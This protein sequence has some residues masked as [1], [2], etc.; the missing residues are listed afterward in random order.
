MDVKLPQTPNRFIQWFR[1]KRRPAT[2]PL[3]ERKEK[4]PPPQENAR[5]GNRTRALRLEGGDPA[6]GLVAQGGRNGE[7]GGT[8][9]GR[10]GRGEAHGDGRWEVGR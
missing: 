7:E 5:P 9:R 10:G 1:I 8:W 4:A 6:T 3:L 2:L